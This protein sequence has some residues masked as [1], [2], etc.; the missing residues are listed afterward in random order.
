[1]LMLCKVNGDGNW[2]WRTFR[3]AGWLGVVLWVCGC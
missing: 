3:D 2:F 1:M